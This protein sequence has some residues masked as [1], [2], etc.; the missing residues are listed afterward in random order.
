[1]QMPLDYSTPGQG[2]RRCRYWMVT[3][4][5]A[6]IAEAAVVW[7]VTPR[8]TNTFVPIGMLSV[9]TTVQFTPSAYSEAVNKLPLRVS[10][11]HRGAV[12][13]DP[14]LFV[15]V[16]PVRPRRWNATPFEVETRMNACAD[17]AS[18]VSRIIT[19]AFTQALTPCWIE[20]TRAMMVPSPVIER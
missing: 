13:S 17:P 15:L 9:P 18:S 20:V 4:S 11:N 12:E 19:P 6:Q 10:F 7:L 5:N 8:P 1:M 2:T 14:E 3:L 16:P